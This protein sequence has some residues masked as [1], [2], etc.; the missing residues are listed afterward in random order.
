MEE[1][2]GLCRYLIGMWRYK[3]FF[4]LFLFFSS[5]SLIAFYPYRH[6]APIL[7][8]MSTFLS[9]QALTGSALHRVHPCLYISSPL[10]TTFPPSP[11]A[12]PTFHPF[13]CQSTRPAIKQTYE[14]ST[15]V[16]H[17]RR[18]NGPITLRSG[19]AAEASN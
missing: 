16:H 9:R 19:L 10:L 13:R 12:I 4:S 5:P 2:T 14:T 8:M 17:G 6:T 3:T 7:V 15:A 18:H 1:S 11:L